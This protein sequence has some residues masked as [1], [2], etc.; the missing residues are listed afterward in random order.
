MIR[1]YLRGLINDHKP[2]T[3]L[4][5]RASNNDSECGEWKTHI[6]MQNNCISTK[7][8]EE[9]RIMYSAGKRV[10]IFMGS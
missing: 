7:D 6:L 3:E 2:T 9:T 5:N 10:E 1:T 4:P 8:F